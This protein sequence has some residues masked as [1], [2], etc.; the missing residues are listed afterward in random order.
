MEDKVL[1]FL[2]DWAQGQDQ[3]PGL[4]RRLFRARLQ[5]CR[6]Q[7]LLIIDSLL[8]VLSFDSIWFDW[9]RDVLLTWD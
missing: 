8:M 6:L 1:L 5:A 9:M 2:N 7:S 3:L 4:P